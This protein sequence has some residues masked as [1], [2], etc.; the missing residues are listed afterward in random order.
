MAMDFG[1]IIRFMTVRTTEGI[2]VL[3][4]IMFMPNIPPYC[5]ISEPKSVTPSLPLENKLALNQKLNDVVI[6]HKGDLHGPEAFAD[7]KGVLYSSLHNGEIVKFIDDKIIPVVQFGKPCKGFHEERICG[8]PLGIQFDKDGSLIAADAYYG[9]FRVDVNTGEKIQ[10]VSLDTEINGK[11]PKLPNA[12][13]IASNG[14]LYW[15]DSSTDFNLENGLFDLFADGTG[16]LIHYNVKTKNN[17]VLIDNLLFANGVALSSDE[18]FVLVAETSRSCVHR[19]YLKGPKKGTHDL[20]IDGLPGLPDNINSDGQGGFFF[21]LIIPRDDYTPV[22][23]QVL[24]PFPL[25]RKLVARMMGLGELGFT[26]ANRV[27]RMELFERAIHLIGHFSVMS[28]VLPSRV[29]IVHVSKTGEI[30]GAL[31]GNN[32]KA[33]GISEAYIFKGEL[34]LGSPM[35]DYIARIP[36]NK[37]GLEYLSRKPSTMTTTQPPTSTT[38]SPKKVPTTKA[39]TTAKPTTT[40]APRTTPQPVKTVPVTEAPTSS[41]PP[42]TTKP[43]TTAKPITKD[44]PTMTAKSTT[45]NSPTTTVKPTTKDSPTTVKPITKDSPI[46]TVKPITKDSPTTTAQK[47]TKPVEAT[48]KPPQKVAPPQQQQQQAKKAAETSKPTPSSKTTPKPNVVQKTTSK[49]A[50]VKPAAKPTQTQS[51][52]AED[53]KVESKQTASE[54]KPSQQQK[55][56]SSSQSSI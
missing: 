45:K 27:Y 47:T 26:L 5:K 31:H 38:P 39:P 28:F 33:I 25:F 44:S 4:L 55:P 10:L 9:I 29:T 30:I 19:Y 18:E 12:V 17:T 48:T 51:K 46:T 20:F 40:A 13:V 2:L 53:R 56:P 43:P 35:N 6:W 41:T 1:K 37:V 32:K 42:T 8:R 49:P 23:T 3:L 36:L 11:K 50:Q 15:T 21:P 24:A 7:Y 54:P 22:P 16:R 34:Y 52:T 14:D